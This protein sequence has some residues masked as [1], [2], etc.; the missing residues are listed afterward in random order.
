MKMVRWLGQGLL[1]RILAFGLH[2]SEVQLYG[3]L[4]GQL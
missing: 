1:E 4:S 2:I 3:G